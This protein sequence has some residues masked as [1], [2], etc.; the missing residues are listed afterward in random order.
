MQC[1]LDSDGYLAILYKS[2]V[3]NGRE[4]MVGDR[5]DDGTIWYTCKKDSSAVRTVAIG[6]VDEN[7]PIAFDDRVAR[8]DYVYQCKKSS[9][10]RVEMAKAGCARSGVK[11]GIGETLEYNSLW[12]TCTDSGP[13]VIGCI[14]NGQRLRD[15][16]QYHENDMAF[17]CT[18]NGD[19]S[20]PTAA[21]CLM[22]ENGVE[23]EKKFG[24]FW[25][26]G[27]APYEYEYTCT[28]NRERNTADKVQ[29]RC[30]YKASEGV[31][32][33]EPGCYAKANGLA[34]GCVKDGSGQLSTKTF[35]AD[36]IDSSYGLRA[37]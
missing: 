14:Y 24:C 37:C 33:V 17:Q 4:H 26:E 9:S 25:T 21:A 2:C 36:K 16:D 11:Y 1:V 13:K 34:V 7:R 31:F 30:S 6:C 8:G 28:Y 15:G 22:R 32:R 20:G 3:M 5:W 29:V 35:P 10:G 12:Y 18:V 19:K 23:T 27:D